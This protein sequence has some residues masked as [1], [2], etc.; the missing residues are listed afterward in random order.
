MDT[1]RGFQGG[2]QGVSSM[3]VLGFKAGGVME[4]KR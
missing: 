1:Y 4:L 3:L 2:L